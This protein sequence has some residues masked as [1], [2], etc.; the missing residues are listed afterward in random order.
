MY[1]L[2]NYFIKLDTRFRQTSIRFAMTADDRT[3][4]FRYQLTPTNVFHC[5]SVWPFCIRRKLRGML[6]VRQEKGRRVP[7]EGDGTHTMAICT[8]GEGRGT[9]ETPCTSTAD[10]QSA[11]ADWY[12]SKTSWR[13]ESGTTIQLNRL[14]TYV[15][16]W[17]TSSFTIENTDLKVEIIEVWTTT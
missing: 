6:K 7:V 13:S 1:Q 11:R 9:R 5:N 3:S 14:C 16:I 12:R 10:D 2:Y 4:T 15:V 8:R 17:N